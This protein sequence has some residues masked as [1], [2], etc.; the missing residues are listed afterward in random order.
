MTFGD[1][2]KYDAQ[3]NLDEE[4]SMLRKY[5][6]ER[7]HGMFPDEVDT[8]QDTPARL[9]F[10]KYDCFPAHLS[11]SLATVHC[12]QSASRVAVF[13]H[14]PASSSRLISISVRHRSFFSLVPR[15][16]IDAPTLTRTALSRWSVPLRSVK[17][18]SV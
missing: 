10:Q 17:V 1:V 8:P 5:R 15:R 12:V 16:S 2:T 9:R 6:E 4:E 11:L 18:V 3:M 13:G 7:Q 14:V